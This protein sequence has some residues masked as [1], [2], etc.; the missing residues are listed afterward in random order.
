MELVWRSPLREWWNGAYANWLVAMDGNHDELLYLIR[1]AAT[2]RVL[3]AA[4][5]STSVYRDLDRHM[6]GWDGKG[7]FYFAPNKIEI[8]LL[9]AS[10]HRE[11][12]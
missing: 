2:K 11:A 3:Y 5:P 1:D 4:G 10:S 6:F 12:A 8:A 9:A 7:A